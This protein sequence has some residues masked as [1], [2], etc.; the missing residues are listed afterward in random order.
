M[1]VTDYVAAAMKSNPKAF[2]GVDAAR[3]ARVS[4]AVLDE[5]RKAVEQASEGQVS[6]IRFGRFAVR[7]IAF[8]AKDGEKVKRVLFV[9]SGQKA[10]KA[11]K[12]AK[13][14]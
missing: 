9:G 8:K 10:A 3:A 6:V 14:K 7:Q 1:K 11:T 13:A 2:S 5:I 12:A 4:A